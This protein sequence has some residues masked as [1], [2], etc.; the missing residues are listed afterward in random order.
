MRIAVLS[1]KTQKMSKIYGVLNEKEGISHKA[2][3]I[4][5]TDQIIRHITISDTALA[6]SVDE[7]LRLLESCKFVDQFGNT[8]PAGP[9]ETRSSA[10]KEP[11][12]F[13]T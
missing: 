8:C 5:D 6:R 7:A 9:R 11:Q 3:F 1:D 4:V 2:L 12:Y 13:S 10:D